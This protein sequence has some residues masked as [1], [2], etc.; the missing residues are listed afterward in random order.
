MKKIVYIVL[1]FVCIC[2]GYS[3]NKQEIFTVVEVMPQY[4]GGQQEMMTYLQK[5]IKYPF[6][7]KKAQFGGKVFVKFIIDSLGNVVKPEIL[8]SSGFNQF[9][10]EALRVISAM[11]QWKPGTQNNR[12]VNVYFNLPIMFSLDNGPI[13]INSLKNSNEKYIQSIQLL[14]MEKTEKAYQIL[15]YYIKENDKDADALYNFAVLH[16]LDKNKLAACDL[17]ERAK[18]IGNSYAENAIKKYCAN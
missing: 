3:Q 14:L 7:L 1:F 18:T 15:D 10:N 4:P 11:P 17:F 13:F 8:K 5:S 2:F 9:D 6:E 16:Y 12:A